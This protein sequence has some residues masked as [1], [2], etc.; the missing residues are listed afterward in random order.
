MKVHQVRLIHQSGKIR[1]CHSLAESVSYCMI[2]QR[3]FYHLNQH[4]CNLDTFSKIHPSGGS[5]HLSMKASH[6]YV[7]HQKFRYHQHIR[8]TYRIMSYTG[9][10]CNQILHNLNHSRL[11]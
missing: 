2:L 9:V 10:A 8:S 3:I 4:V 6:S 11:L 7:H 1:T 5:H